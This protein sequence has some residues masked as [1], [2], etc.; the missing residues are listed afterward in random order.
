MGESLPG[1][2]VEDDCDEDEDEEINS[3]SSDSDDDDSCLVG[4]GDMDVE[5]VFINGE[6]RIIVDPENDYEQDR[7]LNIKVKERLSR[8]GPSPRTLKNKHRALERDLEKKLISKC[9]AKHMLERPPS[10]NMATSSY[11]SAAT[12]S[13]SYHIRWDA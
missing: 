5:E 4:E 10:T 13:C 11:R 6:H 2:I 3:D 8:L 9:A 7:L 12:S 1:N